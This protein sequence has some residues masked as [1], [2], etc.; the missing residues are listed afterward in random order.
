MTNSELLHIALRN[1]LESKYPIA[2]MLHPD[3]DIKLFKERMTEILRAVANAERQRCID[4][5]TQVET[6]VAKENFNNID[7]L[8]ISGEGGARKCIEAIKSL[9]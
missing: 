7:E 4:I 6:R 8:Y 3:T 9:A 1:E 2:S 5:C